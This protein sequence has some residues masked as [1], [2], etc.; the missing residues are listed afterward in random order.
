MDGCLLFFLLA[1][2]LIVVIAVSNDNAKS[3]A[4]RNYQASLAA[5]KAD[6][7]DA[8][9]R[10]ETLRLGRAY[11]NAMRNWRGVSL[12]D[13]IA[14]ANDINAACAG[15]TRQIAAAPPPRASTSIEDRLRRL[16]ELRGKGMI[17]DDEFAAR[18]LEILREV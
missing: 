10:E 3:K 17:T 15:A 18:R 5:L 12:F 8:T 7:T 9:L 11:S 1:G 4:R 14:L 6:P 2:A 16:E 13:E